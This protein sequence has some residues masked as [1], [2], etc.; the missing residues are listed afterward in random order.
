M[1]SP[2]FTPDGN[3]LGAMGAKVAEWSFHGQPSA[4]LRIAA[5]EVLISQ[6]QIVGETLIGIH[7]NQLRIW[8]LNKPH[9]PPLVIKT[10]DT[11]TL[12]GVGLRDHYL[13]ISE[14][15]V[16]TAASPAGSVYSPSGVAP[17]FLVNRGR[18][19]SSG[20]HTFTRM[21]GGGS[22]P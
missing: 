2:R 15:G 22:C 6:L 9:N 4:G 7:G 10:G 18:F 13:T 5:Q 19:G 16:T 12:A 20:D 21:R 14:A 3:L 8:D 17:I 11:L 1:I